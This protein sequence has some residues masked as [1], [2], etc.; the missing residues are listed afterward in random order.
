MIVG[1]STSSGIWEVPEGNPQ[2][3]LQV[4]TSVPTGSQHLNTHVGAGVHLSFK[5]PANLQVPLVLGVDSGGRPELLWPDPS[6]EGRTIVR[7]GVGQGTGRDVASTNGCT[8]SIVRRWLSQYFRSKVR[9]SEVG[10]KFGGLEVSL[11]KS[12]KC[13]RDVCQRWFS[14]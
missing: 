9:G 11:K 13:I 8:P 7:R 3:N 14:D 2:K 12:E 1:C 4:F 6:S 5:N 10:R